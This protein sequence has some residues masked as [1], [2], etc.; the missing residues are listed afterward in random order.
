M[1]IDLTEKIDLS[2]MLDIEPS[3]LVAIGAALSAASAVMWMMKDRMGERF[4]NAMA[5]RMDDRMAAAED[6]RIRY[7]ENAKEL[8]QM[9]TDAGVDLANIEAGVIQELFKAAGTGVA[10]ISDL[11]IVDVSTGK[12]MM[13]HRDNPQLKG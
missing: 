9:V 1:K 10:G 7:N 6:F 5:A 13:A 12:Y 11:G 2:K 4:A 8:A 3:E